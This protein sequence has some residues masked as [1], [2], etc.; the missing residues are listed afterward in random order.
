M[1][2][3]G[4]SNRG[5]PAC[6]AMVHSGLESIAA[7][8]ITKEL[9]GEVK[10]AEKG[11]V[12][13]KIEE[14]IPELLHLRT[15]E[16]VFL[17]AWGT[18]TLTYR[19]ED[20]KQIKMWTE[21]QAPWQHLF[22]LHQSIRPKAKGRPTYRVVTQMN[23]QHGYRRTDASKAFR[24][25]LAPFI[26]VTWNAAEDNTFL[27][28]WLT[29][30]GRMATCGVRLS[31]KTMRHK[32]YKVEHLPASLRPTMAAAMVRLAGA[33]P[34]QVMLDPMCGAG[35]IICEQIIIGKQQQEGRIETWGG[36]IEMN[37][38]RACAS[39]IKRVG[40]AVIAHWDARRLPIATESV[41]R[42]ISNPPFGK[43][44]STPE[45]IGPLYKAAVREYHRVLKPGGK[46]VFLVM[47]QDVLREAIKGYGWIPQ[48][49]FGV[50]VL[51][52]DAV[53][54]VWQKVGE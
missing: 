38:L 39:N 51:G 29:I 8:E 49:Q 18:D 24:Q 14:I 40:P 37:T 22:G 19:A 13:F 17:L 2:R 48:R 46:A 11:I 3:T 30:R 32:S 26:P 45:D 5:T 35:T 10:K 54:S 9:G 44:L 42:I 6:Y 43:Q 34:G 36:D 16:D 50:E 53:I 27:E 28:V 21:K 33:G 20:L 15:V 12:V 47:E 7:D 31:D 41:D 1:S 52:Q 4:K 23:G 25:G